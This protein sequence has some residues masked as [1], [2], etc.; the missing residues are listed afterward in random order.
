M[1]R[2][3]ERA[4]GA[5][6]WDVWATHGSPFEVLIYYM[7]VAARKLETVGS[8][9]SK[10]LVLEPEREMIRF[11]VAPAFPHM[12]NRQGTGFIERGFHLLAD[13][14]VQPNLSAFL[15]RY[16]LR[17]FRIDDLGIAPPDV[18]DRF[19]LETPIDLLC[20]GAP[21]LHQWWKERE[22]EKLK[23]KENRTEPAE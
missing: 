19:L 22:E 11:G 2:Y 5:P 17:Q 12:E 10:Y 4:H 14:A 1:V 9:F 16:H 8:L 15:R 3:V 13:A 18:M 7:H 20:S 23:P 6:F 21:P